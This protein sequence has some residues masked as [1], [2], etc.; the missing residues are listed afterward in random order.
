MSK[1]TRNLTT[2]D[3]LEILAWLEAAEVEIWLDGGWGH[4]AL[5]GEQTRRH[6]DLDLVID[7]EDCHRLIDALAQHGFEVTEQDSPNAFVLT[8]SGGRQVD[9]HAAHFDE[10]GNASYRMRNGEE[11]IFPAD[12][13]GGEGRIAGRP[14]RCMTAELQ[15]RCKTGNFEPTAVDYQDVRLLNARF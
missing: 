7:M 4:D 13:L 8:D 6:D 2:S 9:V 14:A 11:W 5:L 15:M 3:V 10:A 1:K 12:G